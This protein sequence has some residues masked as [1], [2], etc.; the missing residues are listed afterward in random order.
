MDILFWS[1]GKDSYLALEFYDREIGEKE[2]LALLTTYE[3]ESGHVPHQ[4]IPLKKIQRQA[5]HLGRPL[6][7]V[8]LPRDCPNETYLEKLKKT[9]N[10]Q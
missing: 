10:E 9:L 1:G 5:E 2:G 6:I 8:P 7:E 4:E 3:E